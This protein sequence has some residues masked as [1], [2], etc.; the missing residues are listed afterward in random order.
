MI[1]LENVVKDYQIGNATYRA[2]NGIN[3]SIEQGEFSAIVGPSGCG[4][5]TTMNILGLLDKPTSGTYHFLGNDTS[6]FS[7]NQQADYRNSW[8][9][10]IFQSFLLL[11]RLSA[12]DNVALPLMYRKE[13][14][15]ERLKKAEA[16]L[17]KVGMKAFSHHRPNELSGGQQQRVAIA[18]ALVGNPKVILADEP[19]GALDTKTSKIVMDLLKD[20][21]RSQRITVLVI[22]HDHHVAS[23][24]SRIIKI[25]DGLIE[26]EV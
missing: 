4:K 6:M 24:C 18:R 13:K 2:L 9:G 15:K 5:T 14:K 20:I 19:T 7:Q 17:D 23:Q 3:L 8:L 10:F 12:I 16:V 11:P 22:T 25:N 1:K 21:H 26:R